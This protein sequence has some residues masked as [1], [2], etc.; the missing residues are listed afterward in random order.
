MIDN[1]KFRVSSLEDEKPW[2]VGQKIFDILNDCLQPSSTT[3]VSVAASKINELLPVNRSDEGEKESSDQ[4]LW[5]FWGLVYTLAEQIP[6]RH[7]S[8]DTLASFVKALRDL[9]SGHTIQEGSENRRIWQDL[10]IMETSMHEE[11]NSKFLQSKVAPP[12]QH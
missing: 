4:F 12:R 11:Q 1:L 2:P 9:P 6:A 8:M 3:S 5:E 7:P 10:P